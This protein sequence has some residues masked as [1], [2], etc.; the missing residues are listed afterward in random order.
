MNSLGVALFGYNIAAFM[1]QHRIQ[2][3]S[4][5]TMTVSGDTLRSRTYFSTYKLLYQL[6][7]R[8]PVWKSTAKLSYGIGES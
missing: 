6:P 2:R 3:Q 4:L 8:F 5:L 7:I 1:E